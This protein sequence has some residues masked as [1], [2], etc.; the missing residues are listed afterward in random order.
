MFGLPK[1]A[2]KPFHMEDAEGVSMIDK[3]TVVAIDRK[4]QGFCFFRP[5]KK[6]DAVNADFMPLSL[7]NAGRS[8]RWNR[9]GSWNPKPGPLEPLGELVFAEHFSF[10]AEMNGNK[11][12]YLGDVAGAIKGNQRPGFIIFPRQTVFSMPEPLPDVWPEAPQALSRNG[13]FFSEQEKLSKLL[14][15]RLLRFAE[16]FRPALFRRLSS[17]SAHRT[18]FSL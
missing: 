16:Q 12:L 7:V 17:R 18:D 15:V 6:N 8:G 5:S 1:E 14:M 10:S 2:G 4:T 13:S 3:E 11:E 9:F